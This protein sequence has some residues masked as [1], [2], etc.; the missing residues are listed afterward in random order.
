MPKEHER[1]RKIYQL[2]HGE[3]VRPPLA[4]W[5]KMLPTIEKQ[6]PEYSYNEVEQVLGGI[7]NS[8]TTE[9]KIKIINEYQDDGK[10]AYSKHKD[11][12]GKLW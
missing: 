10:S 12:V 11:I 9:T 6:Y 7:W 3:N 8:Y 1:E 2:M 5:N 4:W